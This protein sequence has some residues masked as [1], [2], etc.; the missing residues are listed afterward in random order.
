MHGVAPSIYVERDVQK[1]PRKCHLLG[2]SEVGM[3]PTSLKRIVM[4]A[5]LEFNVVSFFSMM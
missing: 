4:V 1:D 2:F 3:S 5:S